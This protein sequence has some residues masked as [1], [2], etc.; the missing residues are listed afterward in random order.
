MK[1]ILVVDDVQ[2]ELDMMASYL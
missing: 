2:S 1:T